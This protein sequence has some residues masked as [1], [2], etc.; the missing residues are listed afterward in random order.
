M[1]CLQCLSTVTAHNRLHTEARFA[2]AGESD[3]G[4]ARAKSDVFTHKLLSK[5][6]IGHILLAVYAVGDATLL[7]VFKNHQKQDFKHAATQNA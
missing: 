4:R 5:G 6:P 7:R 1:I 3:V 2:R